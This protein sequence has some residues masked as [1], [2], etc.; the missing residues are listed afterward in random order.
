MNKSNNDRPE[1]DK[2]VLYCGNIDAT[3]QNTKQLG[4]NK[5]SVYNLLKS[6]RHYRHLNILSILY[7]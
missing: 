3:I 5:R 4:E 1:A 7:I 6:L 2:R